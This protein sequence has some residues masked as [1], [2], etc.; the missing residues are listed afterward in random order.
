MSHLLP[1]SPQTEQSPQIDNELLQISQNNRHRFEQTSTK[2]ALHM[3]SE[4]M[5]VVQ[6]LL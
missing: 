3:A 5:R 2:G 4:H 1:L 6:A